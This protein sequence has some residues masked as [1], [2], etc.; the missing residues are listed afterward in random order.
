MG[1]YR[2]SS[3]GNTPC[4]TDTQIPDFLSLNLVELTKAGLVLALL[5]S[6]ESLLASLVVDEMTDTKHNSDRNS[7]SGDSQSRSLYLWEFN[8]YGGYRSFC[9]Q[10]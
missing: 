4:T 10:C 9:S 5:G 8:W 3:W 1:T 7:W 6:I 2:F